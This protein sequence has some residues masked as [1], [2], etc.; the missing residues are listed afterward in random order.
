MFV[1]S[2]QCSQIPD[3]QKQKNFGRA[4]HDDN[5]LGL[6]PGLPARELSVGGPVGLAFLFF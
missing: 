5:S 4:S 2:L 6:P 3:F 1:S